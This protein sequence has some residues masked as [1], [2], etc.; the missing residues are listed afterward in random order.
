MEHHIVTCVCENTVLTDIN[1][2][3]ICD[4]C[5]YPFALSQLTFS[6]L[7]DECNNCGEYLIHHYHSIVDGGIGDCYYCGWFFDYEYH[8]YGNCCD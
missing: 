6:G 8:H 4:V 1:Q 3:C 5:K 2:D 7:L